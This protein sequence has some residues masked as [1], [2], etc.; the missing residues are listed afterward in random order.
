VTPSPAETPEPRDAIAAV[1]HPDPYPYYARL[2]REKPLYYDAAL[3]LW[4]ASSYRAVKA[5][6]EHPALRVRPPAEPVPKALA[7]T[8]VGDVFA[9]LV[10]MNDGEFHRQHRPGVDQA[11]RRISMEQVAQAAEQ[12]TQDL[13]H[14]C[15]TNAFLSAVP[16]QTM[17]RLL[18]VPTESLDRTVA[19][20][21]AFVQG[22][23]ANAPAQVIVRAN[24]AV[25]EL[26]GE[27][28]AQG[29]DGVRSANRIAFMQQSLDATAGL[30]GNAALLLRRRPELL[31]APAPLAQ[32][33]SFA[34]EVARWDSP[35]QNTRRFA[36]ED[37]DL[38][39]EKVLKGQG[40]LVVL[41]S[42]NRDEALN[43]DPDRFD[44]ERIDRRSMSFGSGPHG[45][46]G[47][48]IAVEIAAVALRTVAADGHRDFFAGHSGFRPLAN[49][50]IPTFA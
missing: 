10:R 3:G 32:W 22:I 21:E 40:V 25:R 14:R 35:V 17:A 33:R 7:G 38:A 48:A 1:V 16:V 49:A 24:E 31:A 20:V 30:L 5:A 43:A 15:D 42:A 26:M 12:A 34:A 18:G 23:G 47:E 9:Q 11:A 19:C 27:G 37:A 41:A 28:E 46:P 6:L 29:L 8:P 45:C 4:V 36:A 44:L 50:R 39:G 2:R 13:V